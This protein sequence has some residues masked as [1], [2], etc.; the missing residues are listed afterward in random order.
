MSGPADTLDR[1]R[2]MRGAAPVLDRPTLTAAI[3]LIERQQ[4]DAAHVV[5]VL[6]TMTQRAQVL[7]DDMRG[8]LDGVW[9]LRGKAPP[10]SVSEPR[11]MSA[12][13]LDAVDDFLNGSGGVSFPAALRAFRYLRQRAGL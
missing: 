1:L 3:E 13:E 10:A 7:A 5:G 12:G 4:S 2:R 8:K 6:C 9:H 11:A